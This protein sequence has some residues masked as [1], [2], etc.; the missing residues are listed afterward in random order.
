MSREIQALLTI[1][2]DFQKRAPL[3]EMLQGI[4]ERTA[5]LLKAG[6]VSLRLFDTTRTRLLAVCRAGEQLHRSLLVEFRPGEG[7]IGWIAQHG[8][9]IRTGDADHDPRF[10]RRLDMKGPMGSY[11][12]MPLLV[13]RSC[14]GVLSA[15]DA[16]PDRFTAH[17]E[18]FLALIAAICAPH[19]EILRRARLEQVDELTGALNHRGL[20]LAIPELSLLSVIAID[21]DGFARVN[22]ALGHAVG[23]E[24]LRGIAG[25]LAGVLRVGD[26]TVRLS[27]DQFLL[28]L[29]ATD[30]TRAV[31][32]AEEARTRLQATGISAGGA[33]VRLTISA[34]VAERRPN[35]P[36]EA[37]VARAAAVLLTAKR[38]GRNR[39]EAAQ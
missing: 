15:S 3:E 22:E 24:A 29:P 17:H 7:L 20:D 1:V 35:E 31:A 30:R 5:A 8:E 23:D 28:V 25:F 27:E 9:P 39:T 2:R 26:T 33:T 10:V 6:R 12:G 18:D 13:D 14:I 38:R 4:V 19:I 34:G 37:L 36:R 11:L 32:I 16:A 21:V